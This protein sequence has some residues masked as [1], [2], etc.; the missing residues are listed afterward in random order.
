MGISLGHA[1][2]YILN[3]YWKTLAVAVLLIVTLRRRTTSDEWCW[4]PP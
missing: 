3:I 1:A 4:R 2:V